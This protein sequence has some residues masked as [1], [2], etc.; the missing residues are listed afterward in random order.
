MED[1]GAWDDPVKRARYIKAYAEYD[2][3]NTPQR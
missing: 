1:V 2:R 3:N